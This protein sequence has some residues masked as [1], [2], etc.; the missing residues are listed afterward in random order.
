[1]VVIIIGRELLVTS[2]RGV[3]ESSGKQYGANMYGKIKMVVQS[4]TVGWVLLS[5][6][7]LTWPWFKA[8]GFGLII[9]TVAITT[10]SMTS[11]L[12]AA[13]SILTER[14]TGPG[15]EPDHA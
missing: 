10:L 4:V 1:M 15:T 3:L 7:H 11:Y 12:F 14:K 9:A 6:S 8:V 2:L 13:R 5:L